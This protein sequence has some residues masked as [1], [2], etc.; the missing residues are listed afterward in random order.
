MFYMYE[1]AQ[2]LSASSQAK[3]TKS[4]LFLVRNEVDLVPLTCEGVAQW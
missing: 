2:W 1:G 4:T 3:G